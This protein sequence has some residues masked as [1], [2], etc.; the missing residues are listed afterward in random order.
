MSY[1]IANAQLSR[2]ANP[3]QKPHA[4]SRRRISRG[5]RLPAALSTSGTAEAPRP[6]WQSLPIRHVLESQQFDKVTILEFISATVYHRKAHCTEQAGSMPLYSMVKERDKG[7]R[8]SVEVCLTLQEIISYLPVL[9]EALDIIFK[10]ARQMEDIRPSTD[11]ARQLEGYIMSTLFYEP[12]TRTRLSF[13]SAMARL[14][15]TVLSTESAGQFSSAAKGETLEGDRHMSCH[16]IDTPFLAPDRMCT[17]HIRLAQ[18]AGRACCPP[19]VC[20]I[21]RAVFWCRYHQDSGGVC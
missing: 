15:G 2:C 5:N 6:P 21:I 13:E 8:A 10:A 1:P 3:L 9:Q 14:G 11:E 18:H 7:G 20:L 12:S 4:S 19:P 16:M 17:Y